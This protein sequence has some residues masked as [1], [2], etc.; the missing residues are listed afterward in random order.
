MPKQPQAKSTHLQ[1]LEAV[2]DR[3]TRRFSPFAILGLNS[4]E[5]E[6][7]DAQ[8]ESADPG[9]DDPPTHPQRSGWVGQYLPNVQKML[10][11]PKQSMLHP[12]V[13]GWVV[14]T[15]PPTPE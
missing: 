11:F 7:V 1:E 14:P 13:G 4:P 8:V 15:H 10:A 2:F 12:Q 9:S 5:K 6:D 3:R